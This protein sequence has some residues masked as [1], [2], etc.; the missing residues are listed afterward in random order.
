[1]DLHGTTNT[2]QFRVNYTFS[3]KMFVPK[4]NLKQLQT[5]QDAVKH[6]TI[7]L[8]EHAPKVA[9]L[10]GAGISTASGIPCYR[11]ELGS[12]S[13][14]HKP[15]DHSE[16]ISSSSKRARFWARSLRG[17]KYFASREPTLTHNVLQQL[18]ADSLISGIIT[19][20]VDRLHHKAGS[21]NVCELHGRGDTVGCVNKECN[22]SEIRV[23]YTK[24]MEK[25]NAHWMGEYN[26]VIEDATEPKDI[27][28]DGDAHL[29]LSNYE[30]F[31]VPSCPKCNDILMPQLTFFG[32]S[33]D[34]SIKDEA[35]KIIDDSDAL[36]ILGSSCSVY[37]AYRLVRAASTEGKPIMMINI[38]ETR[39]D[40]IVDIKLEYVVD[41]LFKDLKENLR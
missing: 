7:F 23:E 24:K 17:Y 29:T 10:T 25:M 4:P 14:G 13:K 27:R 37:S 32:G 35:A 26:L 22:H 9:I 2:A 8:Q 3:S 31:Q 16:F 20:N 6:L 39:V 11:G 41:D 12:Y 19:Q 38:G 15:V 34:V 36:L 5:Y 18:E 28:A 30:D 21:I 33:I 1:M 40:D